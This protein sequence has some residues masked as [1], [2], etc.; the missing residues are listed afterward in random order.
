MQYADDTSLI[1]GNEQSIVQA[2]SMVDSFSSYSGLKLNRNNTEAIWIGCW[3]YRNKNI[4]KI[5]WNH[6]PNNKLKVLGITIQGDKL[7]HQIEEN[8]EIRINKCINIIKSWKRRYLTIA[9]KITL[10]KSF[11]LPQFL[12]LASY[13]FE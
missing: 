6:H 11:L 8:I 9:G 3:K 2:L 7:I 12:Y 5:R 1:C 4:G 13:N 10:V